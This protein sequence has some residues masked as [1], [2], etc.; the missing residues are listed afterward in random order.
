MADSWL[1]TRVRKQT[2]TTGLSRFPAEPNG[3]SAFPISPPLK[4][5]V[6]PWF[7]L[8]KICSWVPGNEKLRNSASFGDSSGI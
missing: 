3:L 1:L 5:V 6:K 8:N 4:P 7:P 2:L